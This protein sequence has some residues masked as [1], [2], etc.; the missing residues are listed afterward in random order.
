M[1]QSKWVW[2]P[3][4]GHLIV[5]NDCRFHLS[6]YVGKYIVSTVGEY[7]PDSE[8]REI[9]ANSRG[10]SL[11]GRGD[12]R[13]HDYM[14]KVG[15]EELGY[16]RTY[17]TMVFKAIKAKEISCCPFRMDSGSEL[18]FAGYNTPEEAFSG[19][20]KLCRKWAAK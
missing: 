4:A 14:K 18:D 5:G 6:T 15:F 1:K 12:T 8:I 13:R 11:V 17:E 3:H 20:L 9:L 19:H 16:G 10:V 2:M 7:L